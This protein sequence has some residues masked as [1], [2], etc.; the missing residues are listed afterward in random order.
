MIANLKNIGFTLIE[1]LMVMVILGIIAI[2]AVSSY[3]SFGSKGK[4]S[5]GVNAIL[6]V[7]LAEEQYRA[8]NNT[9]GT[10]AQVYNGVSASPQGYYTLSVSSISATGYTI[11][12]TA[13]GTQA[14]DTEGSTACASLQFVMNNGTIT[15]TPAVCW[16][17]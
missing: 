3:A 7:S 5:D 10:L 12:A 13:Q 15:K 16:P 6:A 11:T 17:S 8:N 2:V 1:L 9:Y 4:R 14:N